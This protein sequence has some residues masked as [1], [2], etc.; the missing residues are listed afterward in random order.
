MAVDSRIS[1]KTYKTNVDEL[2]PNDQ[3]LK[4]ELYEVSIFN[5][6]LKIAPG[7]VIQ[8]D[9]LSYCYVYAIKNNKVVK[10]IGVYEKIEDSSDMFDLSTFSEGSLCLFD[11]YEKNPSLI[12][13]L[14]DTDTQKNSLKEDVFD[15][16]LTKIND[17]D[18]DKK[19][20]LTKKSYK[21]ILVLLTAKKKE[22]SENNKIITNLLNLIKK[23]IGDKKYY[24]EETQDKIMKYATDFKKRMLSLI[25]SEPSLSLRFI[26]TKDGEPIDDSE[27]RVWSI[28]SEIK[29]Y[30]IVSE[31]F[32]VIET[33]PADGLD[34]KYSVPDSE[35]TDFKSESDEP[36]S[37]SKAETKAESKESKA[38]SKES[39]AESKSKKTKTKTKDS[40]ESKE[41]KAENLPK[42][43]SLNATFLVKEKKEE[44]LSAIMEENESKESK[45]NESKSKD[46]EVDLNAG[47]DYSEPSKPFEPV[48]KS[49]SKVEKS[50]TKVD[51]VD[52]NEVDLNAVE[53]VSKPV[54][55]SRTR[56]P[57]TA[58][59]ASTE[60]KSSD[61][62]KPEKSKLKT[63]GPSIRPKV[64]QKK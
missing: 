13:E 61:D 6:P 17:E 16:I 29:E 22:D 19:V 33:Y 57:K 59:E 9:N 37:F 49:K 53:P 48:S 8:E 34:P 38:E 4:S 5:H 3:N 40:K 52:L 43:T 41:S 56:T 50:K 55:P 47:I 10:K 11:V 63:P 64:S 24:G 42:G 18:P 1:S 32:E 14:E 20:E 27:F 7:L 35:S 46:N 51:E 15:F 60:S 21:E 23:T 39:K 30:V 26:F 2:E 62:S 45:D 44:P 25:V 28:K 58:T 36:E 12:L 31:N 54:K